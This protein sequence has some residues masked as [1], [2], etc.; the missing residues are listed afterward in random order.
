MTATKRITGN[1]VR[2]YL[3]SSAAFEGMRLADLQVFPGEDLALA[4]LISDHHLVYEVDMK[5]DGNAMSLLSMSLLEPKQK[6]EPERFQY[7][8]K[9]VR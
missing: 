8:G 7:I 6:E 1:A 5:W 9:E 4:I 3:Q 2:Q